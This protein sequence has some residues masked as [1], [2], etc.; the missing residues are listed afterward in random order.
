MA[1]RPPPRRSFRV[2]VAE[3]SL[4]PVITP[5]GPLTASSGTPVTVVARA[6]DADLPI[7]TLTFS[8]AAAPAGATIDPLMGSLRVDAGCRSD[9]HVQSVSRG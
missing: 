2:T 9:G 3:A 8:L 4:T 1:R 6:T 7:Q 5:I